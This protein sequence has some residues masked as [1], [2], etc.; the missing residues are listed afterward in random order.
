M[1][2]LTTAEISM[3]SGGNLPVSGEAAMVGGAVAG[4]AN[5]AMRG[6]RIGAILGPKGA[7]AGAI[8][9]G[10]SWGVTNAYT[11]FRES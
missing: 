3:V 9:G 8:I 7:M 10:L 6:A 4:A 1:R 11:Q 5:Q 2:E